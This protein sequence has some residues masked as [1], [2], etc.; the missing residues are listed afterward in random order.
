MPELRIIDT[1]AH[2]NFEQFNTDREQLYHQLSKEKIGVINVSTDLDSVKQVITLSDKYTDSWA[3][4]GLHPTDIDETTLINLPQQINEWKMLLKKHNKIV[5]IGEIG[6]DYFHGNDHLQAKRQQASLRQML[7]FALEV[8]MPVVF[9]CR[10]AY[11]DLIT[12]LADYPGIKGVIHCF[13]GNKTQAEHFLALGLYLSFTATISYPK[14]EQLREVV[15]SVPSDRYFLE[16]DS[17]FLPYQGKR[18]MRN[19]PLTV[20]EI[21]RLVSELRHE[22]FETVCQ[23]TTENAFGFFRLNGS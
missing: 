1:H 8:N 12:I 14:N 22:P 17:P 18:G 9:H 2:L 21:A 23:N 5:A 3:T 16:T 7:T 4:I 19:D 6:L 13:T 15:V 20:L 11:G 10:E